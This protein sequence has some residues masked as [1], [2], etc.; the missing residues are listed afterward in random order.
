MTRVYRQGPYTLVVKEAAGIDAEVTG[1]LVDCWRASYAR[2]A[3]RFNPHAA[4]SVHLEI[5]DGYQGA[6]EAEGNRITLSASHIRA[7]PWDSDVMTHEMFHIVQAYQDFEGPQWAMEGL[8]D[9]AR[10][11]Y[12]LY[13]QQGGWFLSDFSPS[14]RYTDSYRI[15]ARFLVWLENHI[16]GRIAEDLDQKLRAGCYSEGFWATVMGRGLDQLWSDYGAKPE[17]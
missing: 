15:T 4:Q 6:A 9:Y 10:F 3:L 8:A 11:R 7:R 2:M 5:T 13:N 12:G 1:R 14:Q 17:L 16:Y